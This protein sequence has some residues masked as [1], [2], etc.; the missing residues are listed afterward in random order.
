MGGEEGERAA[1]GVGVTFG[2]FPKGSEHAGALFV[3]M[4]LVLPH[5]NY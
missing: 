4:M 2:Q 3:K 5:A 1:V